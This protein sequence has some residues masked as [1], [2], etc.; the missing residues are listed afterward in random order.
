M[1]LRRGS[2]RRHRSPVMGPLPDLLR[3]GGQPMDLHHPGSPSDAEKRPVLR[4]GKGGHARAHSSD[5]DQRLLRHHFHDVH[6]SQLLAESDLRAVRRHCRRRGAVRAVHRELHFQ[7]RSQI[8]R[9]NCFIGDHRRFRRARCQGRLLERWQANGADLVT[10]RVQLPQS[11]LAKLRHHRE[12]PAVRTALQRGH[13]RLVPSHGHL[14]LLQH[15]LLDRPDG[16]VLDPLLLHLRHP[17]R[18]DQAATRGDQSKLGRD[19]DPDQDARSEPAHRDHR[20]RKRIGSHD[21]DFAL[22]LHRPVLHFLLPARLDLLPR[23]GPHHLPLRREVRCASALRRLPAPLRLLRSPGDRLEL[24]RPDPRRLREHRFQARQILHRP[25]HHRGQDAGQIRHFGILERRQ[26]PPEGA[27]PRLVEILAHEEKVVAG[28]VRV[29]ELAIDLQRPQRQVDHQRGKPVQVRTEIGHAPLRVLIG[30]MPD[31][32]GLPPDQRRHPHAV[33]VDEQ[34][35]P[36]GD[37]DVSVLE[38]AVRELRVLDVFHQR[39]ELLPQGR[40][41]PGLVQ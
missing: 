29:P 10:V 27:P 2:Q 12:T 6:L 26:I 39:P 30:A 22:H 13:G 38:V 5:L 34:K 37:Q 33:V 3:L 31:L 40:Q 36:A 16:D 35:I 20:E 1:S 24:E 8:R 18:E 19:R 21:L 15:L 23:P 28:A 41:L 25:S 7:T 17:A 14:E 9:Q 11:A 4:E 32:G